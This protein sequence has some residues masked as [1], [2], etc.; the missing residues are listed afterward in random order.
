[1]APFAA[2]DGWPPCGG[3]DSTDDAVPMADTLTG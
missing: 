3:T 1:M 2:G